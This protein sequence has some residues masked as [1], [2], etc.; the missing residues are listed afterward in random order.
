MCRLKD[1]EWVELKNHAEQLNLRFLSTPGD[2]FSADF[3]D[4]LGVDRFKVASDSANNLSFIKYLKAKGKPLIISSG[5][6]SADGLKILYGVLDKEK[7]TILHCVSSYPLEVSRANIKRITQIKWSKVGYSDHT[8]S[9]IPPVMA[10]ANGVCMIE[11]HFTIDKSLPG[12][13][14]GMSMAP[15][16]LRELIQ[17]VRDIFNNVFI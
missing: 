17:K 1:E 8:T 5:A 4:R 14:H 9:L 12:V 16:E 10:V 11:K 13:D 15:D 2:E 3:L 6:L 7:D